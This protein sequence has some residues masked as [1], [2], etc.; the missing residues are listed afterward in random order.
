[1]P[2]RLRRL[3]LVLPGLLCL[4]M[5]AGTT[6]ARAED[7]VLYGAGSLREAMSAIAADFAAAHHQTVQ[8]QF[9]PSGLMRE[10]IEQGERVDV[11][12]SADMGHPLKLRADGKAVQVAM[13]VRNTLCATATPEAGLTTANFLDRLL[14]PAVKLGTS[15][16]KADP[17]GDYTWAMFRLADQLRPGSYQAL[18]GKA[19]KIVGG[20]TA[21]PAP[22][23]QDPILRADQRDDRLLH[24]CCPA[25]PGPDVGAAVS[26]GAGGLV[27]R[28]RVRAGRAQGRPARC[29]GPRLLHPLA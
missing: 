14:D 22:G 12:T 18:D 24:E 15:T 19:Q 28:T 1:M 13:F 25:A 16:P 26:G 23:S 2:R 17:S 3:L 21:S 20:S 9:G 4:T 8:T 7:L 27:G 5:L 11:F 29:P 6:S 10:R